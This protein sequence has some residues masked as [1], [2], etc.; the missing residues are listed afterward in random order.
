[1]KVIVG[2]KAYLQKYDLVVMIN[3]FSAVP[4]CIMVEAFSR[5]CVISTNGGDDAVSFGFCFDMPET[6]QFLKECDWILDFPEY[7][8]KSFEELKALHDKC[9]ANL[10]REVDNFNGSDVKYRKEHFDECSEKFDHMKL[11]LIS[12]DMLMDCKNGKIQMPTI[13][14]ENTKLEGN[15]FKSFGGGKFDDFRVEINASS[16]KHGLFSRMFKRRSS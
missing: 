10:D 15:G 9:E 16:K 13:P 14:D 8:Q 4:G 1:M 5:A 3:E 7:S 11:K 12:L 6:V 2:D